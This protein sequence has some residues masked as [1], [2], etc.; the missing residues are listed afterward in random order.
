MCNFINALEELI[1]I[2]SFCEYKAVTKKATRVIK[3]PHNTEKKRRQTASK[4]KRDEGKAR[5]Q[6]AKSL[7]LS[8]KVEFRWKIL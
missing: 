5:T 3:E 2:T 4:K 7:S 1:L 8:D 6:K